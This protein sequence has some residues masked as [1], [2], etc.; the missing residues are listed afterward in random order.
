MNTCPTG[1]SGQRKDLNWIGEDWSS[2]GN[3]RRRKDE[4]TKIH[5]DLSQKAK[6]T[7]HLWKRTWIH[8]I[9]FRLELS[10]TQLR[11]CWLDWQQSCWKLKETLQVC[12]SCPLSNPL[13]ALRLP[14]FAFL[15]LFVLSQHK[16]H[17]FFFLKKSTFPVNALMRSR[18]FT[19]IAG[20]FF[21]DPHDSANLSSPCCTV[22][23]KQGM[24][25]ERGA[26]GRMTEEREH[27]VFCQGDE[28]CP[29]LSGKTVIKNQ[30]DSLFSLAVQKPFW[31]TLRKGLVSH[32]SLFFLG[33]LHLAILF[34]HHP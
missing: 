33:R 15:K 17:F 1:Y 30:S 27:R 7:W 12:C 2:E 9:H 20:A 3:C 14:G 6:Y 26:E 34:I 16:Y 18:P 32:S 8:C 23:W 11:F 28:G 5:W 31:F 21:A 10:C 13:S 22:A 25:E 29:H 4:L 19:S 24:A